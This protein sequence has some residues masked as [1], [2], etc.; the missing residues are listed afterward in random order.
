MCKHFGEKKKKKADK[1]S[2]QTK[3]IW[4]FMNSSFQ[5][6]TSFIQ[7]TKSY[8]KYNRLPGK[9]WISRDS[10]HHHVLGHVPHF[11]VITATSIELRK[12]WN[13]TCMT[14]WSLVN[15]KWRKHGVAVK[16]PSSDQNQ[17]CVKWITE[18]D[19]LVGWAKRN[20]AS[21]FPKDLLVVIKISFD[22]ILGLMRQ[23]RYFKEEKEKQHHTSSLT[24]RCFLVCLK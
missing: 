2:C 23:K 20:T 3:T 9:P 16:L 19:R 14:P 17:S 6:T 8:W 18:R 11:S 7:G 13:R 21:H 5:T 1:S 10:T 4:H 12:Y 24:K 15:D 22:N